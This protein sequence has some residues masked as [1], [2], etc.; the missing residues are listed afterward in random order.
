MLFLEF[1]SLDGLVDNIY[2]LF[3]LFFLLLTLVIC[4]EIGYNVLLINN[5][6]FT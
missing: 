3:I 2:Y 6:H 4:I 1:F 5:V